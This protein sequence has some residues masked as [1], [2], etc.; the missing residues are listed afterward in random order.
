MNKEIQ[1]W[2]KQ[3]HVFKTKLQNELKITE[4]TLLPVYD[5]LG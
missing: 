4:D 2:R 3:Y 5:K 1:F